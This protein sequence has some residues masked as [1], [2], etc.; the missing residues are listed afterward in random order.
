MAHEPGT[1]FEPLVNLPKDLNDCWPW[2]GR[3]TN[4]G[5]P[6]K[7][8]NGKPKTARKWLWELLFGRVPDG[9]VV[10]G[11]CGARDCINPRHAAVGFAKDA[12]RFDVRTKLD[13]ADVML[14]KR[15][16]DDGVMLAVLAERYGVSPTTISDVVRGK[17]WAAK[18]TPKRMHK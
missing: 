3:C 1:V 4:N 14:I 8:W 2:I 10:Y 13:T 11:T 18:R 5:T 17:S 15:A 12:R 9:L 16:A 7:Q 6:I